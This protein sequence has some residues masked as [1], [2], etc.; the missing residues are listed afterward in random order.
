MNEQWTTII[1]P[2]E[3]WFNFNLKE[4]VQYKDLIYMFVKRNVT[5]QYK[6]TVLGPLWFIINPLLTT[7]IST[8]VFGGIAGI[9]SDGIPYFLFYLCSYTLWSYFSTC[10]SQT[11][12]TF[13]GNVS[14]MGKVYFPRITMPI[15][16]V[17]FSLLNSLIV[18]F[19]TIITMIIYAFQGYS[20]QLNLSVLLIPLFFIQTALLGLGFG[21]IVSALTV[22]YRDLIVLISFGLQ[23]WMY[24]TPIVY[25]ISQ[26]SNKMS[27]VIMLNPMAPII[28]NFRFIL[29][30][31]GEFNWFYWIISL[32]TTLII[33]LIGLLLFNRVEKTFM[34]TI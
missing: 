16:T 9:E 21:I 1:K 32:I 5:A 22:K 10:V 15:A 8:I 23:L 29:L 18:F 34:D 20:F 4:L 28:N 24:A 11:S 25:P 7:F 26:L 30:G 17:T 12:A 6:Q 13:T 31:S 2:K 27:T 14:I 19:L 33:L 3:K